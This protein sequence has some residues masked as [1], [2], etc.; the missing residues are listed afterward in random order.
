[1]QIFAELYGLKPGL[2]GFHV[3]EFGKCFQFFLIC[4]LGNLTS[5]CMTA[6]EHF[7]P[8]G[9]THGGPKDENRRVG[10]LGNVEADGTGRASYK[11]EDHLMMLYG[12]VN[13]IVDEPWSSTSV[14]MT[15]DVAATRSLSRQVMLEPGWLV[16]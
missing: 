10:D 3:H 2:H 14:R 8:A 16:A 13:N 15:S 11:W 4:S 1:V 7:N 5:G 9:K 12:G 6:G